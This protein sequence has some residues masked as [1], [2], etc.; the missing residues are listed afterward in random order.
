MHWAAHE[1]EPDTIAT[2][3]DCKANINAVDYSNWTPLML[4]THVG[5]NEGCQLL[6]DGRANLQM[7]NNMGASCYD[8]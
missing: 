1:A 6:I 8:L 7:T 4:C 2:L 5:N 3:I